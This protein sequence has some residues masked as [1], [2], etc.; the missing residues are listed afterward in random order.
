M[1]T[2]QWNGDLKNHQFKFAAVSHSHVQSHNNAMVYQEYFGVQ[3]LGQECSHHQRSTL[4]SSLAVWSDRPTNFSFWQTFEWKLCSLSLFYFWEMNFFT[5]LWMKWK[6]PC[7]SELFVMFLLA[8]SEKQLAST[9]LKVLQSTST[10]ESQ[11]QQNKNKHKQS[12][13]T[14]SSISSI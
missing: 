12:K 11:K 3:I 9:V 14:Y 1:S 7:C 5:F 6:Y 2:L 8:H 4:S 13:K 10:E